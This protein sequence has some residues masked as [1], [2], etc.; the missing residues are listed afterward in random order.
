MWTWA[1]GLLG[2]TPK[3]WLL[4]ALG[5]A[6][7]ATVA[8][9]LY[10]AG[11]DAAELRATAERNAAT[12]ETLRAEL[13]RRDALAQEQA[14][15]AQRRRAH[16]EA[17]IGDMREDLSDATDEVKRCARVS[18][19]HAAFERLRNGADP[20]RDDEGNSADKPDR[21]DADTRTDE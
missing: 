2:K 7:L 6:A 16:L 12:V 4:Y 21:S 19:P 9:R 5:A 10:G 15:E 8:W 14:A 11:Y 3:R 1:L 18:V 20:A 17:T 13:A